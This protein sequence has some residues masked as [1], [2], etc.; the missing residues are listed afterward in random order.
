V[1]SFRHK[2]C[3]SSLADRLISNRNVPLP[4]KMYL[5]VVGHF[6]YLTSNFQDYLTVVDPKEPNANAITYI[7]LQVYKLVSKVDLKVR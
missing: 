2:T 7:K 4:L 3:T 6:E 1:K 5:L